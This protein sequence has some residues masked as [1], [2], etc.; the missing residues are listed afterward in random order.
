MSA[1]KPQK[2]VSLT[3]VCSG[4]IPAHPILEMD[5]KQIFP[6]IGTAGWQGKGISH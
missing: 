1:G 2:Q 6:L 5:W 4:F 3:L